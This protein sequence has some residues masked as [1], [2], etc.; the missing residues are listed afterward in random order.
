MSWSNTPIRDYA[1]ENQ[2]LSRDFDRA[3]KEAIVAW[4]KGG[5]HGRKVLTKWD[6]WFDSDL[7][8]RALDLYAVECGEIIEGGMFLGGREVIDG[9]VFLRSGEIT[10]YEG[11][12]TEQTRRTVLIACDNILAAKIPHWDHADSIDSIKG[13]LA[14]PEFTLS[15]PSWVSVAMSG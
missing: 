1:K 10:E 4:G 13:A 9:G 2:K 14:P 3:P 12:M 7:T 8:S 15:L 6:K 11:K 5:D